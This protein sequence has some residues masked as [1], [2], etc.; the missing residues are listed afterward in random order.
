VID[1]NSKDNT[2]DVVRKYTKDHNNVSYVF[3]IKQGLSHAR[4]RGC[5]E[6][7]S[8]YVAYIDDDA[9]ASPQWVS[10]AIE[11]IKDKSP[12]VFGGPY[13]SFY[14][15]DKPE[16]F[17]DAY[18]SFSLEGGPR[19]LKNGEFLCGTNIIFKRSI[20][21]KVG[22][23]NT[24]LG[25][26]GSNM[27]YCEETALILNVRSNIPG[28]LIFY[29]QGLFVYHLVSS[30]K[31]RVIWNV[32]SSFVSGRYYNRVSGDNTHIKPYKLYSL[33]NIVFILTKIFYTLLTLPVR[34][35]TK[36]P[37]VKNCLYEK[38]FKQIFNL[39]WYFEQ[40]ITIKRL[41]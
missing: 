18:G 20:L 19:P 26:S 33:V 16:W 8:N 36:Y 35:R 32:K 6:A 25:M 1:N 14:I 17:K 10:K 23:F 41:L 38:T 2:H 5:I 40:F 21:Q 15:G 11:I 34:D 24:Q 31:L 4:N 9:K 30:N 12:D 7:K 29:D 39:G 3:E 22:G 37:D 13:Y 28:A 27:A